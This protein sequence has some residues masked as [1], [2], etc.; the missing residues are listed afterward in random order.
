M[1]E[2]TAALYDDFS[3]YDIWG[4]N[5]ANKKMNLAPLERDELPDWIATYQGLRADAAK[6]GYERWKSDKADAVAAGGAEPG[7]GRAHRACP[8]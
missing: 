7:A 6:H 3:A 8:N 4:F 5:D 2:F 1:W